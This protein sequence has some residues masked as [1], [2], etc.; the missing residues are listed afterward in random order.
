M[1]LLILLVMFGVIY[2][3]KV[4]EYNHIVDLYYLH[5]WRFGI[6]FCSNWD[7]GGCFCFF[8]QKKNNKIP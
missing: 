5:H 1:G 4:E 3:F 6:R 2:V 7:C 8:H